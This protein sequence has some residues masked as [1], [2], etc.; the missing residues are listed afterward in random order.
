M[1]ARNAKRMAISNEKVKII[2]IFNP[3][4]GCNFINLTLRSE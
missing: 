1:T 2:L 3:N 4:S